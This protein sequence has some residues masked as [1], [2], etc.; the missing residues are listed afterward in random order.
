MEF[1]QE[2]KSQLAKLMATENVTVEH[3][4]V[5]TASFNLA[6]RILTLP[7]WN[8]MSGDMYDLLT[9]H[10]VGHA[11][12]T[13]EEGWHNAVTG[14]GKFNKNY[15]NFLN[16]V[17]DSRIE[18][19][20][21]RRFPG[22]KPAFIRAYKQLIEQDFFGIKKYDINALPFIDRLN[23]YTKGGVS[24]GINFTDIE[25][26]LLSG[27]EACETWDD[28]IEITESIYDYSK[29]EQQQI[30]NEKYHLSQDYDSESEFDDDYA[31]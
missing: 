15:K 27:V 18:K 19:K 10:E 6:T 2:S 9:G 12:E 20:M 8:D 11:L 22:L 30:Q 3:R 16:V 25:L 21:K 7:I 28:V 4:K 1:T 23:L 26:N 13:P 5:Q 29:D 31:E 17:E 14:T 24:L